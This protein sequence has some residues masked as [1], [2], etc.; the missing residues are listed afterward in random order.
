VRRLTAI[1][2]ANV[3][4]YSRLTGVDEED[5]H[6]RL[7]EHLRVL[8]DPKVA[9]YRGHTEILNSKGKYNGFHPCPRASAMHIAPTAFPDRLNIYHF[10]RLGRPPPTR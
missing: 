10:F 6:V 2:A 5:T 9:A 1:F 7:K 3:A 4:G 8:I